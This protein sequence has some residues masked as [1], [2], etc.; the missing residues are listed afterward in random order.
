M[1]LLV[2]LAMVVAAVGC[3]KGYKT[4]EKGEVY[5]DYIKIKKWKELEVERI[6]P[7]AVKDEDVNASIE[8]DLQTLTSYV[9]IKDRA[10]KNGDQVT[11]DFVG[12]LNGVAFEGGTGS[13]TFILG[14][15]NFV[16]GFQ[17]GVVGH[18]TGD[19]FDV[20]LTFPENYGGDLGGKAVVFTMKLN[21]VEEVVVPELT[22]ET[23]AKLS[24]TAKTVAEYKEQVKKDLEKSNQEAADAQMQV[25]AFKAFIEQCEIIEYPKDRLEEAIKSCTKIYTAQLEQM[26]TMYY[27][28]TLDQLKESYGMSEEELLGATF[29]DIAK[30]QLKSEL[31]V[32]LMGKVEKLDFSDEAYE[33]FLEEQAEL[34]GYEDGDAVE[35]SYEE[36]YGEGAF[37]LTFKQEQIAKLVYK[38]CVKVEPKKTE[39]ETETQEEEGTD[40]ESTE[41]VTE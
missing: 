35:K 32:E 34:Y 30:E 39:S 2:A 6:D 29:E 20:P 31:A 16:E 1:A 14:K 28:M 40:K 27:G 25:N 3:G 10:A 13:D 19:E 17:E 24:K 8:S 23:V 9:E 21:K 38:N 11:I 5:Y 36:M 4:G 15:G 12:K 22:D 7:V 37:K 33:T 41:T 18:K 26:A